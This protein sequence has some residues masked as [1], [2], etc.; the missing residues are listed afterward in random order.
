MTTVI[1]P[2]STEGNSLVVLILGV[3]FLAAVVALFVMYGV[4]VIQRMTQPQS[5]MP[6]TIE[7]QIPT[8]TETPT[9]ETT[10]TP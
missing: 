8:P 5:S 4:P 7:V 6:T 3:L 1:N 10:P 9:P 2:P